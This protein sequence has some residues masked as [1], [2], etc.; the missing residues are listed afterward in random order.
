[1]IYYLSS[2]LSFFGA[3]GFAPFINVLLEDRK[4]VF[5][6]LEDLGL[7]FCMEAPVLGPVGASDG[8]PGR[9]GEK[10]GNPDPGVPGHVPPPTASC[11]ANARA[12]IPTPM[13]LAVMKGSWFSSPIMFWSGASWFARISA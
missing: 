3:A 5:P 13:A 10:P 4:P 7:R 6:G 12:F 8:P 9:L 2:S 1:M 11:G